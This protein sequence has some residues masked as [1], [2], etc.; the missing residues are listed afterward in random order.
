MTFERTQPGAP[1]GAPDASA[2]PRP[3]ACATWRAA[4]ISLAALLAGAAVTTLGGCGRHA[5]PPAAGGPP[6]VRIAVVRPMPAGAA[7]LELPGRVAAGEEVVV[8]ARRAGRVTALPRRE[9]D[10]FRVGQTLVVFDAP[11][12]RQ[13]LAA[14]R[15]ALQAAALR[16]AQAQLQQARMDSLYEVRIA[17][18][19]EREL[20][21]SDR[22]DAAAALAAAQ[23][24]LDEE[25]AALG[26][27]APFDGVVVRRM[28]D[29]GTTVGAGQPLLA[30][31]S[32]GAVEILAAV[33]ESELGRLAG[34]GFAVR[35]GDGPWREA[36]LVRVDGM[37]DY[38]TRTRIARLRPAGPGPLPDAGAFV[39]VRITAAAVGGDAP[40]LLSI[41]EQVLVRR[42][43]LTGVYVVREGR[44][45]LRWLRLGAAGSGRVEVLGG[46]DAGELLAANPRGLADGIA[47]VV[48][49]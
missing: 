10:R 31:R 6:P 46:L 37:T 41:P 18:L 48:G 13:A 40:G 33:P 38:T 11:E 29:P 7:G 30:I 39:H 34:A 9:G 28:L 20:A 2:L 49:P 3:R 16:N 43:A 19:R 47:V 5:R 32:G 1:N 15:A 25:S 45:R 26:I 44:A 8:T 12:A 27:P 21:E 14:A 4:P 42:G 23:A 22:R 36:V 17:S 24:G 35:S